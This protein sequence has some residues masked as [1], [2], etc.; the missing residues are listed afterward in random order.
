MIHVLFAWNATAYSLELDNVNTAF[1]YLFPAYKI[2]HSKCDFQNKNCLPFVKCTTKIPTFYLPWSGVMTAIYSSYWPHP[3]QL[4]A[5]APAVALVE[6][7]FQNS[8][9]QWKKER[10]KKRTQNEAKC[11]NYYM[12]KKNRELYKSAHKKSIARNVIVIKE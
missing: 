7:V 5:S 6:C 8:L 12:K 11:I 9:I 1:H 10:K 3:K 4:L 2:L